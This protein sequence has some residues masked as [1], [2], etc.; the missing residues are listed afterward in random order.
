M[1]GCRNYPNREYYRY[2]I[3]HKQYEERREQSSSSAPVP[4]PTSALRQPENRP[5][6]SLMTPRNGNA[7]SGGSE[8]P[9]DVY[10]EM[11]LNNNVTEDID[12]SK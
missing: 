8:V 6:S 7:T 1:S 5:S 2:C 4:A 12:Y 3:E 11:N 9:I 10:A